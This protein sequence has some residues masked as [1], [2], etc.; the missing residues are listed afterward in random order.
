MATQFEPS[1]VEQLKR[2]IATQRLDGEIDSLS[3][4]QLALA[5]SVPTA[6]QKLFSKSE[7]EHVMK[8]VAR[9]IDEAVAVEIAKREP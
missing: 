5:C 9:A 7:I 2:Y 1:D 8:T 4:A 6:L 3:R